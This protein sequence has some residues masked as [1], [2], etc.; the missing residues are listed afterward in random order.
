MAAVAKKL[1]R[2]QPP[3]PDSRA[4]NAATINRRDRESWMTIA[5]GMS[6]VTDLNLTL[7]DER[8]EEEEDRC[9]RMSMATIATF[10]ME[11]SSRLPTTSFMTDHVSADAII[12]ASF[13]RH[14]LRATVS[15][16]PVTMVHARL[17]YLA[18]ILTTLR[19]VPAAVF[20]YPNDDSKLPPRERRGGGQAAL[21]GDKA[22]GA[23]APMGSA[24]E[25]WLAR[26][27]RLIAAREVA[28]GHA[29]DDLGPI[30]H[31][32]H[33]GSNWK[34]L[35]RSHS[36]RPFDCSYVYLQRYDNKTHAHLRT[37]YVHL[38][39]WISLLH[40]A[41]AFKCYF[42]DFRHDGSLRRSLRRT[43]AV[44]RSHD[45]LNVTLLHVDRDALT[46]RSTDCLPASL[47]EGTWLERQND[48]KLH[49]V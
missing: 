17:F 11:I 43:D 2:G 12:P 18:C 44:F 23:A 4:S 13:R 32:I 14:D 10:R 26:R 8:E 16:S 39:S 34:F 38:I 20:L 49:L 48:P 6:F 36:R 35:Y 47:S 42:D 33:V 25:T 9:S 3:R 21:E 31:I 5:S 28:H 41:H 45:L 1:P 29:L 22:R 37:V 19:C 7:P 27:R 15:G 40:D 30:L 46:L 24:H